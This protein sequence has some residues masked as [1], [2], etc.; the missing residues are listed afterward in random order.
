MFL[1]N[2]FNELKAWTIVRRE[3]RNN[4]LLFESIGLK[5]DWGGRL[6]KVINRDPEIELGSGED[7]VFLRKELAEVTNVLV[8]TNV[9]DILAYELKPLEDVT[10]IGDGKE[11]YEHGYLITLTPAWN[12]NK[13][14]VTLKSLFFVTV[15]FIALIGGIVWGVIKYLIPYIQT[16]C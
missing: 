15:G 11:E 12:L 5:K 9:I 4:Q 7:E 6:Y 14:Y 10:P 2:F 13:Q 16:I 8:R 1:K 3:Y